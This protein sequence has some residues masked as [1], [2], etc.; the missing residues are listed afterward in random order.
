MLKL[1]VVFPLAIFLILGLFLTTVVIGSNLSQRFANPPSKTPP[2]TEITKLQICPDEWYKNE[3]PCVYQDSPAECEQQR[4]EYFI[5]DGERKEL[6][7][8]DVEW[9]KKNCEVN[10]PEVVY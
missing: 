2:S 3:Q 1:D 4:K 8:V 6:E 5:I 9:V 10:K 7:E